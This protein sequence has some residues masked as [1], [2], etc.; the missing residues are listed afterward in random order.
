MNQRRSPQKEASDTKDGLQLSIELDRERL[1][2]G[3]AA[4]LKIR[5][6]N[7]SQS[8]I[9]IYKHLGWGRSS[10][11]TMSLSVVR[12]ALA[13]RTFLEDA[14]HHP[15]FP[16]G[17]FTT[18]Q[19]GEF[20]ERERWLDLKSDGITGPGI[21]KLTVWYHSPVPREFAPPGLKLWAAENGVLQSKP[22]TLTVAQ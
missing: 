4:T 10:S 17:D 14:Q 19:P 9:T 16:Q 22:V 12:G 8:P 21:Y 5:L 20:I 13:R 1:L 15:P 3:E 11:L 7:V 6:K 18:I 2:L